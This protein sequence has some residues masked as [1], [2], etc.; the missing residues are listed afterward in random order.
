MQL[1]FLENVL[2]ATEST[3]PVIRKFYEMVI[4]HDLGQD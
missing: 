3:R 1:M 2:T 4:T